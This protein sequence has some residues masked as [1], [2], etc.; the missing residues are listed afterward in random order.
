[1]TYLH[2][3]LISL[4][5]HMT[6]TYAEECPDKSK[7]EETMESFIVDTISRPGMEWFSIR[8]ASDNCPGHLAVVSKE[9]IFIEVESVNTYL[10]KVCIQPANGETLE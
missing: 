7:S 9:V 10:T 1:M 2:G 3:N 6:R 8:I 5:E 4:I